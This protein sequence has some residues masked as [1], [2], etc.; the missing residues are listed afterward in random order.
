MLKRISIG[1]CG[2]MALGFMTLIVGADQDTSKTDS[3]LDARLK[4]AREAFKAMNALKGAGEK[5]ELDAPYVWSVRL[6]DCEAAMSH[7]K[8]GRIQAAQAHVDRMKQ[9]LSET[10]HRTRVGEA[11]VLQ[12]LDAEYH[13]HE[14][15]AALEREKV[16]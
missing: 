3:T 6:M 2:F 11:G 16:R 8:G 1:L 12:S 5:V 4:L 7:T 14:A 10:Q 15:V 13:Y 9:L